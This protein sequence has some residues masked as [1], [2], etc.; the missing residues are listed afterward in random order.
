M[1]DATHHA[2]WRFQLQ[3]MGGMGLRSLGMYC[4]VPVLEK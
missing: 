2:A 4:E 1:D 3:G